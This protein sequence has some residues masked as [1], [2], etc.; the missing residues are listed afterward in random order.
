MSD[1]EVINFWNLLAFQKKE[2]HFFNLSRERHQNRFQ[3]HQDI[4]QKRTDLKTNKEKNNLENIKDFLTNLKF[5]SMA[6]I[7]K[8]LCNEQEINYKELYQKI[9]IEHEIELNSELQFAL[10]IQWFSRMFISCFYASKNFDFLINK[11][12]PKGHLFFLLE[13]YFPKIADNYCLFDDLKQFS[14]VKKWFFTFLHLFQFKEEDFNKLIYIGI[15]NNFAF[16]YSLYEMGWEYIYYEGEVDFK[17]YES[18]DEDQ[19]VKAFVD[20]TP[21]S[22]LNC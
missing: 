16:R 12:K 6:Y 9:I 13:S 14:E 7:E 21:C 11:E 15:K 3:N 8:T 4:G 20:L 5:C 19:Y 17:T 18:Y 22:D 10:K 2:N 1:Q